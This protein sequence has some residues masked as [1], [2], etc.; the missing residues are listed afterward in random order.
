MEYNIYAQ[1]VVWGFKPLVPKLTLSC[2][3]LRNSIILVWGTL[4]NRI[5]SS[6]GMLYVFLF[7]AHY[8]KNSILRHLIFDGCNGNRLRKWYSNIFVIIVRTK[9]FYDTHSKT[10]NKNRLRMLYIIKF[11]TSFI[12]KPS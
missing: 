2:F 7:Y 12:K 8:Y 6:G 4:G 10:V 1:M 5:K 11:T 9:T 3:K